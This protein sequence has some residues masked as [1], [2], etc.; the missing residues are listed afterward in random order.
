M[1]DLKL[2]KLSQPQRERLLYIDFRVNF[3]GTI[4]RNNLEQ[5]FGIKAAASTRDITQYRDIAINNLE[6]DT[7]AKVYTRSNQFKPLF[8]HS[9]DYALS[10]LCH[11]FGGDPATSSTGLLSACVQP[12]A[13]NKPSLEVLSVLSRA[14]HLKKVIK[15]TY[16]STS[17]GKKKREIIPFSL[18]NTGH[19]WH[20]RAYDRRRDRF[21]D[22]VLT[23]FSRPEII[24][25]IIQPH[26]KLESDIQWNRIVEMEIVPHPHLKY[27]ESVELDY[28]ISKGGFLD[29]GIRA[30][31]SGYFLRYWNIDCTEDN[32]LRS[33]DEKE[34]REYQLWL[35][36]PQQALYKVKNALLAPGFSL[37]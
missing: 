9:I 12:M 33:K 6:Y 5:R 13:L 2:E 35:N 24:E 27:K 20:V 21:S 17:S 34:G 4:R 3:L 25:S 32:S 36:N 11:G 14:I 28:S 22:F 31:L 37:K 18:I 29:V 10:V 19:R 30:A 16:T 23:R 15:T 7:K 8:E 26:E 1:E